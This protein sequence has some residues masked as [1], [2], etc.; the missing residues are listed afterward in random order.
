[1][2][3]LDQ[4][5]LSVMEQY[6]SNMYKKIEVIYFKYLFTFNTHTQYE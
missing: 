6:K 5:L 1:M 3:R 2:Y 4:S